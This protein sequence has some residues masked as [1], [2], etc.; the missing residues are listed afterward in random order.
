LE[1]FKKNAYYK[2][3]SLPKKRPKK[4]KKKRKKEKKRYVSGTSQLVSKS[5]H[6]F[7]GWGAGGLPV[8]CTLPITA[9][10]VHSKQ[11]REGERKTA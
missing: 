2:G 10:G 1:I 4:K 6:L 7:G 5:N 9:L 8:V 3:K 11:V